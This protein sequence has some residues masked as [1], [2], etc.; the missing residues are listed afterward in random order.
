MPVQVGSLA[1][2]CRYSS[3]SRPT[4]AALT[5]SGMSLLTSVTSRPSAASPSATERIRV[6]FE[7]LRKPCGSTLW[8]AWLSST[9]SVPPSSLHNTGKS[10]R[11]CLMRSSSSMRSDCRANQPSSGW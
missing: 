9:R 8:S 11:P 4:E 10:S 1:W 5:R 3:A 6:S 7:S 2:P